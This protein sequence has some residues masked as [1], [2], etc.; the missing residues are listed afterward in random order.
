MQSYM[1]LEITNDGSSPELG[2]RTAPHCLIHRS[3]V[4]LHDIAGRYIRLPFHVTEGHK[5]LSNWYTTI[6]NAYGNPIKHYGDLDVKM[7]RKKMDQLGNIKQL[8]Y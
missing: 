7:S 1:A 8:M 4:L 5:T 6:L 2:C 3:N